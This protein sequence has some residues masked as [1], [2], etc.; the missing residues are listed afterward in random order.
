LRDE[1]QRFAYGEAMIGFWGG[2]IRVAALHRAGDAAAA[3]SAW[4]L[5]EMEAVR[6]RAV[7]ELVQVAGSHANARD[8]LEASGV[9]PTYEFLR[10]RYGAAG[11]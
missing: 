3:R 6:L 8:G 9:A 7:R 2:L 10:R 1:A 5:V 11:R 4:P